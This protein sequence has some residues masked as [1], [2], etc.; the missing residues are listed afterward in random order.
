MEPIPFTSTTVI[1]RLLEA[2][3]TLSFDHFSSFWMSL[4]FH[5]V[6]RA[7]WLEHWGWHL[8]TFPRFFEATRTPHDPT[9][10]RQQGRCRNDKRG[11]GTLVHLTAIP[12]FPF[13]IWRK[14]HFYFKPQLDLYI[15]TAVTACLCPI[16]F[17]ISLPVCRLCWRGTKVF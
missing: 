15:V 1:V 17:H 2:T 7:S 8:L 12:K 9:L 4:A 10:P 11:Y 14:W 16:T 5:S 13:D 6:Q 3:Y